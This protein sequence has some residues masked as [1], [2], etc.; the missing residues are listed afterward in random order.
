MAPAHIDERLQGVVEDPEVA[1]PSGDEAGK[2][3]LVEVA[4]ELVKGYDLV[5]KF[6]HV[7]EI[8]PT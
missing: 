3:G 2:R 6:Q 4:V 8:L 1:V 7:P 5:G